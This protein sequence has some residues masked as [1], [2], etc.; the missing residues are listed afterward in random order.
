MKK[1]SLIWESLDLSVFFSVNTLFEVLKNL[2]ENM[3][4]YDQVFIKF[5]CTWKDRGMDV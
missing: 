4:N 3:S 2:Y 1:K 5:N